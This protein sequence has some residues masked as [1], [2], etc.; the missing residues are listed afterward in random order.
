MLWILLTLGVT[1]SGVEAA[2]GSRARVLHDLPHPEGTSGPPAAVSALD[3]FVVSLAVADTAGALRALAD[4]SIPGYARAWLTGR[5]HAARHDAE[6]ARAA[7]DEAVRLWRRNIQDRDE[8]EA[9]VQ[10]IDR[11]RVRAAIQARAW[12]RAQK[13]LRDPLVSHA[14][15]HRWEAMLGVVAFGRGDVD[16]AVGELERA[17]EDADDWERRSW[18]FAWRSLAHLA[19]KDEEAAAQAWLDFVDGLRWPSEIRDAVRVWDAHPRL[20]QVLEREDRRIPLVRWL[21]RIL[22]RED[23]LAVAER[24]WR[25]SGGRESARCFVAAAEQLYRLRRHEELQAWLDQPWPSDLD[26]EEKASLEAYPW[27]VLRRSGSSADIA[28]GFDTV[29]T[30][31]PDTDRGTE[32][33]WE[34]A[35]MWELSDDLDTAQKRFASYARGHPGAPFAAAAAVRAVLL[36][37]RQ[38]RTEE[39]L[40]VY[41]ELADRLDRA[42]WDRAAA[43]WLAAR[44]YEREGDPRASDLVDALRREDPGNPFL[45]PPAIPLQRTVPRATPNVEATL[46]DLFEQQR[47]SLRRV[48]EE[49]GVDDP[50]E[51]DPVELRV[52]GRMLDFGVFREG[53]GVLASYAAAHRRDAE[54]QL[55]ALA[56]AWSHGRAER[57][58]RIGTQLQ[59]MLG[60]RSEELD[61]ALFVLAQPT[62]YARSVLEVASAH[63]LPPSL[64]WG[65]V[66]RESFYDAEVV[67]LAGAYG[68]MQL[69]PTTA[70]RVAA[71]LGDPEPAPA[72]LLQPLVNLRLGTAYLSGLLDES[73]GNPYQA[74]AA[75]NAGEGNGRRWAE[76]LEPEAPPQEM[77]LLISYSETRAYVYHVLRTWRLYSLA[78]DALRPL[79]GAFVDP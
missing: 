36:L 54:A 33:L 72:E 24:G 3:R 63:G 18:V 30:R 43:R 65:L 26:A 52:A 58:A 76:R 2:A 75:Y 61:E 67:S 79:D 48:A 25:D 60:G 27:G 49:L 21:V 45:E 68:L 11:D 5:I 39:A 14:G 19:R 73:T 78:Y 50:L 47:W 44:A 71:G 6:G 8:M 10:A 4:E 16:R 29:A 35:W 9:V 77:I 28:R 1:A 46:D 23:A 57:Q 32:A 53:D 74:L 41:R 40:A 56:V 22:R 66:R 37:E 12:S 17:W 64:V 20:Q 13:A 62:P 59:L 51:E 42:G 55:R 34:A 38:G 31:Y 69:L 15:D 70:R 7:L